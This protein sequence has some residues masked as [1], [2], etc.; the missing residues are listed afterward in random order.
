VRPPEGRDLPGLL[1]AGERAAWLGRAL[2]DAPGA[3]ARGPDAPVGRAPRDAQRERSR[4]AYQENEEIRRRRNEYKRAWRKANPDKVRKQKRRA[5]LRQPK[6]VRVYMARYRAKHQ[7]HYAEAQRRRYRELHPEPQP[8]ACS[9]CGVLVP[10]EPPGKPYTKCDACIWP[11]QLR[12][13]EAKRARVA[14]EREARALLEAGAAVAPRP[15]KVRRPR[16]AAPVNAA[17]QRVCLGP[18]P[19]LGSCTTVVEGRTKKC[20]AC[21]A[22]DT[23]AARALLAPRAGRGRRTDLVGQERVA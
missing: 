2:R 14:A 18:Q 22:A 5:G 9:S 6:R 16:A 1:G 21:R 8:K 17:G 10:Y 13:R 23:A 20:A 15:K 11:H 7:E 19:T 4:K 3:R 12:L